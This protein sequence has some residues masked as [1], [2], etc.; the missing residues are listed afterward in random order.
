MGAFN[1]WSKG[2]FLEKRENRKTITVAMNLLFGAAVTTRVN[3]LRC[4]GIAL[5]QQAQKFSPLEL[6][7]IQQL[8]NE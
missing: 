1:Q 8:L 4:Q 2:T 7:K 3:S 6:L 5:P